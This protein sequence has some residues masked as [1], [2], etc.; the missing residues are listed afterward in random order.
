M[1]LEGNFICGDR[2]RRLH[3]SIGYRDASPLFLP[4]I[5]QILPAEISKHSA[6]HTLT[7]A[8]VGDALV[9]PAFSDIH[10]HA[11]E[12]VSGLQNYKED[13]AS[14]TAAAHN[15]GVAAIAVMPNT[16]EP[17]RDEVA[18]HRLLELVRTKPGRTRSVQII[19]YL[20]VTP[21]GFP[22]LTRKVPYK[23][24]LTPDV[25]P[26][27]KNYSG[28]CVSF[29]CEDTAVL[30]EHRSMSTHEARRPALAE[31]RAV[32]EAINLCAAHKIRGIIC[33]LS[34]RR[35]LELCLEAKRAGIS[36]SIEISPHHLYFCEEDLNPR[37]A[38]YLQVN[39][40]LRPR[41]DRDFL[42]DNLESFDF[43]ATDHAPHSAEE[44]SRGISGLPLLD[45]YGGFVSWLL[46]QRLTTPAIINRLCSENPGRFISEFS[47]M[48][49]GSLEVGHI[50]QFSVLQ[51]SKPRATALFTKCQH[52]PF[53]I[54]AFPGHASLFTPPHPKGDP[55]D[56]QA[57]P[58]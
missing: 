55:P 24:F 47:P 15:G 25:V 12:D 46:E 39:P 58:S 3:V 17:P 33:H 36:I 16:P 53:S 13:F 30:A 1:I 26:S 40:P 27:L 19:P 41:K 10:V 44:K 45:S 35:A 9:F 54:H 37:N 32:A 38:L 18:Y 8:D 50:A 11:R 57:P 34:T 2:T 52:S 42:L 22:L 29:H 51:P 14:V 56:A 28:Q 7:D 49:R 20:P 43:L 21:N 23:C 4:V 6:D 5:T 48:P 31:V